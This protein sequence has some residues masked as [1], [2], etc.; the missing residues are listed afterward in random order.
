MPVGQDFKSN[1]TKNPERATLCN[2][3]QNRIAMRSVQAQVDLA[4]V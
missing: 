2:E 1:V 4:V 3:L